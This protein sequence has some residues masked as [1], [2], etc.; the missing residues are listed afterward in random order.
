MRRALTI[1]STML[2]ALAIVNFIAFSTT[3]SRLGGSA[4]NGYAADGH[5]FVGSHGAYTEVSAETWQRNLLH[6]RSVGVTHTLAIAS[7]LLTQFGL[8][9]YLRFRRRTARSG[10]IGT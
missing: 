1:I 3:S 2:F 8:P 4:M 7:V 6:G 9:L 10:K 5:Y